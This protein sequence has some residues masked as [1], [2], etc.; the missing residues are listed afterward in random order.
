MKKTGTKYDQTVADAVKQGLLETPKRLPSWLFYDEEGDRIFQQI[1][2]M[3]EYYPTRCEYDI[4]SQYRHEMLQL[5]TDGTSEFL[6]VELGAGDGLK[7]EIILSHFAEHKAN[8]T[9][10]PVDISRNALDILSDRLRS[11]LPHVRIDPQNKSYDDA[12][13][14]LRM[15]GVRKVIMFMGANIGNFTVEEAV[16][17]LKKLALPLEVDDRLMIGFDLKKNPRV[18]LEAYDDPRGLTASFNLNLLRRL[19]RQLGAT[20]DIGRFAHYPYYDPETGT[21]KSF[22]LSKGD[23]EVFIEAFGQSI[24]FRAWETIQTEVSQKYDVSMIEKMLALSGFR[25]EQTFYDRD[26]YFCDVVARRN[27]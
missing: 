1:M 11:R 12:L 15:P 6:L 4:L 16:R 10:V 9:Y 13:A 20:F 22:L 26:N 23:Q 2:L 7:S 18:I 19:N 24:S 8:F 14:Q 27:A 21:T 25:I 5:F 17:F 3:P